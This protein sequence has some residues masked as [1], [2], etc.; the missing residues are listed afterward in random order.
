MYTTATFFLAE[1]ACI[2]TYIGIFIVGAVYN[3]GQS[4]FEVAFE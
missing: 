3:W 2:L 4:D 1:L